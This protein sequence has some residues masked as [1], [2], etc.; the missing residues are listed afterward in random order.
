MEKYV[1]NKFV[2]NISFVKS[3]KLH[4][5]KIVLRNFVN[6]VIHSFVKTLKL[7]IRILGISFLFNKAIDLT[8]Q[9]TK[10]RND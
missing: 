5:G 3:L 10:F 9:L 2:V 6:I 8:K 7:H 1:H 4:D